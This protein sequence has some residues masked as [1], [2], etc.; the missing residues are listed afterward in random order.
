M[1]HVT[2]SSLTAFPDRL[3]E[4]FAMF[5]DNSHNWRPN[6]WDGIPSERLTAI[7][8]ICHVRDIEA[9]GYHVRIARIL[10]ESRPVLEDIAGEPLAVERQYCLASPERALADFRIARAKTIESISG[11][12]EEQWQRIGIFEGEPTSLRGLMHFLC[13]HDNQHLAGLHWLQG[14]MHVSKQG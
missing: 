12:S 7:E 11:L 6:S 10:R 5:P 3:A 9:D 13:S 4:C 14:K 8:Q 1:T 2:I